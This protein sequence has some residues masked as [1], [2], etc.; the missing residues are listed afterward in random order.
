MCAMPA[1]KTRNA[2]QRLRP[3]IDERRLAGARSCNSARCVNE[4]ELKDKAVL[5]T[6]ALLEWGGLCALFL[7]EGALVASSI[8]TA[9]EARHLPRNCVAPAQLSSSVP[10]TTSSVRRSG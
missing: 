4:L 1:R 10:N 6:G 9:N 8:A 2:R 5:I 3:V 7:D